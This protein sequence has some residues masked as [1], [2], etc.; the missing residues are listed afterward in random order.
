MGMGMHLQMAAPI[1][2]INSAREGKGYFRG[3]GSHVLGR[4]SGPAPE[5]PR[6]AGTSISDQSDWQ[7]FL[8]CGGL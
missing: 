1:Q 3:D 7:F 5:S 4:Y 6:P 8:F 2:V